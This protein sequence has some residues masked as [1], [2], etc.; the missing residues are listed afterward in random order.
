MVVFEIPYVMRSLLIL[1]TLLAVTSLTGARR[2]NVILVM[3]DDQGWGQTS[4]NGHPHLRTPNLDA[5]ARA[6]IRFNRFYAGASNCSPTRASVLTGRSNDRTGV[7][8]HGYPLRRQEKTI[9]HALKAAGYSTGHFGKWHLNGIRG[10]GVPVL[11]DDPL[12]PGVFG[13]DQWISVTNFFDLNPVMSRAGVFDELEG[14]SSEII[15]DQAL[16][17]IAEKRDDPV[18]VVIWFGT[19]HSPF[20]AN[21]EDRVGF[22]NLPESEQQQLGELVAMD[23]AIGTL[24]A[25][26]R[27]LGVAEDTILWFNSDNGGL[28]HWGP[29][30]VGGLRGFKNQVYEGGLRVPALV[31]WPGKIAAGQVTDVPAVTMDIFPTIG[32]LVGLDDSVYLQPLDGVSLVDVLAGKSTVR[33]KPIPFKRME[34]GAVIDND[35]K[36]VAPDLEQDE[37]EL[38]HLV[39][40]PEEKTDLFD[41][42]P[43]QAARMLAMWRAFD[44]SRVSSVMGND[45]PERAVNPAPVGR[46]DGVFWH[47]LPEYE[48][49]FEQWRERPE[50]GYWIK[51]FLNQ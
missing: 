20:T 41:S 30:T 14:D 9:A 28:S 48:P 6:G 31:E 18:L 19:P 8:T 16:K 44:A 33:S 10:P 1:V 32:E 24:R 5:M 35:W 50:Y 4:Y 2:P 21:P 37:F 39:N 27:E 26:L 47:E 13:F 3:S 38:Y 11:K 42:R 23:R 45:Y 17:F 36:I 25:G 46:E 51:R 40:D 22:E 34:G 43:D 29:K 7:Q 49:Y 12:H 15:V